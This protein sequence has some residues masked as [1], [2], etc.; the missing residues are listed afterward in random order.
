MSRFERSIFTGMDMKE[1]LDLVQK[2]VP[3]LMSRL[4]VKPSSTQVSSNKIDIRD[5]AQKKRL[6][7]EFSDL[8]FKFLYISERVTDFSSKKEEKEFEY[9]LQKTFHC[10]FDM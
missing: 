1:S 9:W 3:D 2:K 8:D 4:S 7:F 10:E 5:F 6:V